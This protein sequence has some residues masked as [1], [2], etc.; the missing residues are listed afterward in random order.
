VS[1]PRVLY[2]GGLGRSGS[3]LVDRLLGQVPGC[4]SVGE[5]VHLW[6]R[7]LIANERCGCGQ[8]FRACPFWTEVGERA[9]EGGWRAIDARGLAALQRRVDRNRYVPWM[10]VPA[11][12]PPSWRR[13]LERYA[14]VLSRI[15]RGVAETAAA[16]V[17]VDSSKHA[18]TG[19]L[20]RNSAGIDLRLVHLV[21]DPRG[22]A[23]SWAKL[24][25]RPDVAEGGATMARVGPARVSA[26]WLS[27]NLIF[28]LLCARR[29]AL[30]VR[31]EDLVRNPDGELRRILGLVDR[32]N[33]PLGFLSQGHAE[34]A[35][36]HTVSGH[37]V[38]FQ[39][40][41]IDIRADEEWRVAMAAGKRRTVTTIT[42]PL[43]AE[44]GYAGD[45]PRG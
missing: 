11:A 4:V 5:L 38:R 19:A 1:R 15:Y 10:L 16:Q 21:R 41:R 23:F 9:F 39:T 12:A 18:S 30:L 24:V 37:P 26:R 3:T 40:G 14:E 27:Y 36:Q 17:V 45:R 43:R 7:G 31:Y 29:P 20:L 34:L 44:C 2:V 22:V 28:D 6:N 8:A 32:A 13:A 33:V 35:T 25:A 42:A